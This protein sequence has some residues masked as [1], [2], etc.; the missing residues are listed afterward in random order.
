MIN[1]N[2]LIGLSEG[3]RVE[4]LQQAYHLVTGLSKDKSRINFMKGVMNMSLL[5]RKV[6]PTLKGSYDAKIVFYDEIENEQG[7][8]IKLGL[9]LDDRTYTYC[10]FPSQI[11]YLTSALKR[12]LH[13]DYETTVEELLDLA[14]EKTITVW[15]S[16]NQ[17]Y[18]RMNVAFHEPYMADED[19]EDVDV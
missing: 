10:V 18:G 13:V 8:Y 14:Q 17:E 9:G 6:L 1:I 11:D 16:Y 12:Q 5:Q 2:Y 15:F 7:G 19:E 3:V 4:L